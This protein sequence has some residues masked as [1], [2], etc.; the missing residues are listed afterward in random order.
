MK[1]TTTT[2][3]IKVANCLKQLN[4]SVNDMLQCFLGCLAHCLLLSSQ[5]GR[6]EK[7]SSRS[8]SKGGVKKKY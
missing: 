5:E 2:S 8:P 7:C 4:I 6:E 3:H 1:I